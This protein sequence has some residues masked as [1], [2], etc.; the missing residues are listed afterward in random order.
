[1]SVEPLPPQERSELRPLL[2]SRRPGDAMAAYYALTHPAA[3]VRL[4]VHR[5]PAGRLDGFLVR[6]QTGLDLFRPLV[7]LRT[8]DA[9]S[10]AELLQA[11][12]PSPQPA[13]FSMPE[14]LGLWVLPLLALETTATLRILRL[15][16][17]RMEP[18]INILVLRRDSPDGLPRY[19]IRSEN[20]LL[21]SAGV[22][23]Q[24]YDWAEIFVQT[25]P[26]VRERGYGRSVCAALCR[27]LMEERKSVL[28]AVEE[29]NNASMRLAVGIGFE[30]TGERELLCSG[31]VQH[32]FPIPH[33]SGEG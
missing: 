28:Y 29:R 22:N 3:K 27:Q 9:E 5:S 25:D 15:N 2:D 21:A 8:P 31:S 33:Q 23:W 24:T 19:E 20:R 11:A 1:M 14:P 16:P 7:T 12:F 18:L 6:A 30:D 17:A 4:W 13:L 32:P 26:D 10:A